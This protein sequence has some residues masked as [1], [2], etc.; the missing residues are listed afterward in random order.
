MSRIT[1]DT[2][3]AMGTASIRDLRNHGGD[4][5]DRV[6]AGERITITRDGMPVAELCPVPR[7]ELSTDALMELL[8]I[9]AHRPA[10]SP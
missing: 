9:A 2:E 6:Q 4:I 5:V 8:G 3:V 10:S 7:D 1:G